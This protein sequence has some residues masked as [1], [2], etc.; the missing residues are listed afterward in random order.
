MPPHMSIT[1]SCGY[2][3]PQI[4]WVPLR[5]EQTRS[6]RGLVL[7]KQHFSNNIFIDIHLKKKLRPLKIDMDSL[8]KHELTG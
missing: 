6:R 8:S 7:Q 1:S 3:L 4:M 2:P 5:Q